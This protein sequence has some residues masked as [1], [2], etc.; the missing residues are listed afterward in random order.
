MNFIRQL[1]PA[2]GISVE[3]EMLALITNASISV[4][5]VSFHHVIGKY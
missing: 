2:V 1:A 3:F 4:I 5:L